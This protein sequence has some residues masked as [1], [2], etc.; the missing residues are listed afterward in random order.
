MRNGEH[1]EARVRQRVL[2]GETGSAALWHA[3]TLHGTQPDAA[4]HERISLRYLFA[5]APGRSGR[6]AEVNAAAAR[7][8][9]PLRHPDGLGRGRRRALEAERRQPGLR[10]AMLAILQARMSSTRLPGK[11]MAPILGQPMIGRQIE[12]LRR[13]QG[14]SRIM[15]ATSTREDDDVLAGYCHGL[16]VEVFRGD[17]SD[18]LDRFH[19][20]L[21]AAG[22]PEHFLRLTADCPLTAPAVIDLCIA[23]HLERCRRLHPQLSRLDLPQGV[24]RGGLSDRSAGRRLVAGQ[25]PLRPGARHP[26]HLHPSLAASGSRR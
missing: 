14:I 1:G 20:A 7:P 19:G 4:D 10:A 9:Q 5:P 15:V 17:L 11:V 18:V 8:A 22:R 13:A 24:G 26:L 16:D 3:C 23:R 25:H 2:T 12:R 21:V 6:M